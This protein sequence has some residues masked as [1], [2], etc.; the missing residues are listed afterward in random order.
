MID[1]LFLW[2]YRTLLII[3]FIL[4]SVAIVDKFLRLFGYTLSFISYQPGKLMQLAAIFSLFTIVL[5]LRQIRNR[6]EKNN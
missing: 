4:L 5:L 3:T 2:L 6:L 1:N